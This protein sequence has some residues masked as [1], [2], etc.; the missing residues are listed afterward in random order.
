MFGSRTLVRPARA[1]VL[2]FVTVLLLPLNVWAEDLIK[3]NSL[4]IEK[5]STVGGWTA[6]CD[7]SLGGT[8]NGQI[9]SGR[10]LFQFL[11][12]GQGSSTFIF[13]ALFNVGPDSRTW[14]ES[15]PGIYKITAR[16]KGHDVIVHAEVRFEALNSG[17]NLFCDSRI[18][19]GPQPSSL[20][21]FG[22]NMRS[23]VPTP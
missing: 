12:S 23:S 11:A 21:L 1:T 20:T 15:S 9:Y 2:V 10:M 17:D 4:T 14:T 16:L 19:L 18:D 22:A 6:T 8:D 7:I 3:S 5:D 13:D